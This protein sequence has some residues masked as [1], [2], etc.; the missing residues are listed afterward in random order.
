V[1]PHPDVARALRAVS[2]L[3]ALC[4]RLPHVPT[5]GE[6]A[7][8]GRFDALAASP[9]AATVDDVEA[10]AAGWRR[11]WREGEIDALRT[12]AGRLPAGLI[13]RDRRLLSYAR[14]AEPA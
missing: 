3:R 1:T 14:A 6:V 11:W 4:L 7:C 9:H 2:A 8:L 5:P 13:E 12:M 10:I